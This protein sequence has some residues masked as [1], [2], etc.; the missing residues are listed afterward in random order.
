MLV[1]VV[2]VIRECGETC[3]VVGIPLTG[4]GKTGKRKNESKKEV[5]QRSSKKG[6]DCC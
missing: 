4:E 1:V 3:G 5:V 6:C 2:M